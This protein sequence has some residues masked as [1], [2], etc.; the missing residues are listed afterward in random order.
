M[1]YLGI[2]LLG[3]EV[4]Q[5]NK[6]SCR[7]GEWQIVQSVLIDV[8]MNKLF[9]PNMYNLFQ[10]FTVYVIYD[11]EVL[12]NNKTDASQAKLLSIL[13]TRLSPETV[14]WLCL[15]IPF[16]RRLSTKALINAIATSRPSFVLSSL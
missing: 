8:Y 9:I 15:T 2:E 13:S 14:S 3:N 4:L 12:E 10:Y 7:Q 1:Q 16:F 5:L 6:T 11:P